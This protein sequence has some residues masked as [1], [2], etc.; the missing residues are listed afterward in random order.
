[1]S[2]K[3]AIL[4]TVGELFFS[5]ASVVMAESLNT[6]FRFIK[7][8]SESFKGINL[9]PGEKIQINVGDWNVRTYTPISIDAKTGL[10]QILVYLHGQSPGVK[11]GLPTSKLEMSVN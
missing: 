8:Q 1:M 2:I 11:N 9:M 10:M 4:G 5:S 6:S 7:L 3:K